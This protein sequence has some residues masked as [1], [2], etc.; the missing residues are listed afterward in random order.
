M[1]G[2]PSLGVEGLRVVLLFDVRIWVCG[3]CEGLFVVGY[4]FLYSKVD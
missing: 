3:C 1:F 4:E 2:Y